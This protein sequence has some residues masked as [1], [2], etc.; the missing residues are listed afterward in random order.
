MLQLRP[1]NQQLA[2][3]VFVLFK[4][5]LE[6]VTDLYKFLELV[7]IAT[8]DFYSQHAFKIAMQNDFATL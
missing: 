6:I 3:L 1:I 4:G 5:G 7:L 2:F 8:V